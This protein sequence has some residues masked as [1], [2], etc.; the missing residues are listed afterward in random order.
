MFSA[1]KENPVKFY[2]A[3]L[4]AVVLVSRKIIN[5]VKSTVKT[6]CAQVQDTL[7]KTVWL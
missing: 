3:M 7:S 4:K 5:F 2:F 1:V 6:K